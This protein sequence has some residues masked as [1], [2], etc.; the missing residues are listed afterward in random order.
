MP[1]PQ[2]QQQQ[3][4]VKIPDALVSGTYAN[5]MMVSHTKEEFILDFANLFPHQGAGAVVA[6]VLTSPGHAK[7]I[8][9]ALTDNLKKYEAQ[10]GQI[11]ESKA[12]DSIGF[13][14]A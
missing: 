6:R 10:F 14:T 11:E 1:N 5:A 13:R 3:I 4:Q 7:R 12:T 2:P 8:M 9:A